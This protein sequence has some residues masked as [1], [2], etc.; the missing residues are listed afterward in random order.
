MGIE[1]D[2]V[3]IRAREAF[4]QNYCKKKGWPSS[5]GYLSWAQTLEIRQQ[6]GWKRPLKS[7]DEE[8]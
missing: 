6:E 7:L 3:I 5:Y 8:T 2:L 4:T 1:I